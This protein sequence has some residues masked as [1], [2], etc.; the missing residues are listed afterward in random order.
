MNHLAIGLPGPTEWVIIGV[1]CVLLFGH[2]LPSLARNFG[3]ALPSFKKGISEVNDE[4]RELEEGA[5]R[6]SADLN[7]DIKEHM[8]GGI[9]DGK[10][11]R[12]PS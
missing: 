9:Q 11:R 12:N 8:D 7:R 3:R 5:R 4:I 1:I 10:V 6:A 2:K